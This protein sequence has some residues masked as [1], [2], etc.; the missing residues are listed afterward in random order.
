[1]N[2]RVAEDAT[3][4]LP[5]EL[6]PQLAEIKSFIF[7]ERVDAWLRDHLNSVALAVVA[8]GLVYRVYIAS[9]NY[10][11]PDEALHYLLI[12]Q[13]SLWLAYKA[14]LTNAHPPLFYVILY[15]TQF[16]GRSE[17]MLRMPSVVAGTAFCWLAYRWL[18][19]ILSPAASLIGLVFFT[20]SPAIVALA[21]EVRAYSVMLFC[22][23]GA[24]YFLATAFEKKSVARMWCFSVFLYLAIL[25]HYSVLFFAL[26]LGV[27]VLARI[28]DSQLS[29][30][31]VV[32]WAV[33]Q[34]LAVSEYGILYI[35]HVSKIRKN[36]P[37]WGFEFLGSFFQWGDGDILGF[38]WRK[39]LSI[40]T[41]LFAQR[42]VSLSLFLLFLA[43]VALIVA[44]DILGQQKNTPMNRFGL[45]LLVPFASIW[46]ASLAGIYPYVGSRH[47]VVLAPFAVASIAFVLASITR[48]KLWAGL[49]IAGVLV[50]ISNLATDGTGLDPFVIGRSPK[51]MGLAVNFM[52]NSIPQGD[53]IF[54]DF[55]SSLPATFYFCGPDEIVPT[56]TFDG[57][58]TFFEFTCHGDSVVS[59]IQWKL[60]PI[61]FPSRFEDM[62]RTY[63]LKPG[64]RVW[65]YQ[66]GWGP[67]L[68]TTLPSYDSKFRCLQSKEYGENI[69]IIP[70]VVGPDFQ[71]ALPPGSC[72]DPAK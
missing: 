23:A 41:F 52:R 44:K 1:M 25:S 26:A 7:L 8:A 68:D 36:I 70:F 49:L 72:A 66:T 51:Q 21:A 43:G 50:T 27:Y 46:G 34:V 4:V 56:N 13:R 42:Y 12:H 60:I 22:T 61:I 28:L 14:S 64:D 31:V 53:H 33:G 38:T 32:A 55:Q 47:T 2:S 37:V 10:L 45:L 16:W 6:A 67:N 20:F 24:L 71:P 40:L 69:A 3:E 18:S 63:G 57:R 54:V 19:K 9:R 29:R 58:F 39:T 11:N 30:N 59:T 62:A 15:Y 35:T 65:L 48:Q 17:L 5:G